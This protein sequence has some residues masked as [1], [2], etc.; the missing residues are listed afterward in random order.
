MIPYTN[1]MHLYIR[2]L[3]KGVF[4]EV[5]CR[6]SIFLA[7]GARWQCSVYSATHATY[8]A[9]AKQA[10]VS[11]SI[12]ATRP[13]ITTPSRTGTERGLV[14]NSTISRCSLLRRLFDYRRGLREQYLYFTL[15]CLCRSV[16]W[17]RCGKDAP[18]AAGS[19]A[20][21]GMPLRAL[22]GGLPDQLRGVAYLV[23]C[24]AGHYSLDGCEW[25]HLIYT[26]QCR[27]G[28]SLLLDLPLLLPGVLWC[29]ADLSRPF[30][31]ACRL[32]LLLDYARQP[33]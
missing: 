4:D 20:P 10:A 22:A 6:R 23:A 29:M 32:C 25:R 19:D 18:Y 7:G 13:E 2:M 11:V 21:C 31:L 24:V 33:Q 9:K 17:P 14:G 15:E 28:I 26:G 3:S 12:R 27:H 5:E 30:A 16:C 8:V 1:E